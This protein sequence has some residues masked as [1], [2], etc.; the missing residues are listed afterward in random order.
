MKSVSKL[1][2]THRKPLSAKS[3]CHVPP[4]T[5]SEQLPALDAIFVGLAQGETP[6]ALT[7]MAAISEMVVFET[8][9]DSNFID[10]E[11]EE[12]FMSRNKCRF[13]T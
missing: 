8:K 7:F 9:C 4:N 6:D 1:G 5:L 13:C 12:I 10:R 2:K 3:R 11:I